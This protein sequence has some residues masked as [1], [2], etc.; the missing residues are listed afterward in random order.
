MVQ[1]AQN[2]AT[3][4]NNEL[5]Q[6]VKPHMESVAKSLGIDILLDSRS[7]IALNSTFDIS[8]EVIVRLDEAEKANVKPAAAAK[9]AK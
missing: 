8:N 9:P 7:A 6:K 2:Q 4:L 5:Q 3:T 1:R